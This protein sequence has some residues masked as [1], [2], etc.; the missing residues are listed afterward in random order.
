MLLSE[1]DRRSLKVD[2]FRFLL[3]EQDLREHTVFVNF[4]R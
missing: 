1:E 3:L 4:L 2:E